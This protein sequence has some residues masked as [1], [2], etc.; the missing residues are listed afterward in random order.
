MLE[1]LSNHRLETLKHIRE[2][3]VNDSLKEIFE[4]LGKKNKKFVD[5]ERWFGYTTLN[6]VYRT[7][8]GKRFGGATT[9]DENEGNDNCR[10]ALRDFFHLSGT[11]V[12][13]DA[14]PYLRWLDVGGYGKAMKKAAK[15]L[16][17]MVGGWPEEHKQRKLCGGMK[18]NQD[19][20]DELLSIV[21]DEDEISSYDADTIVKATCLVR[22]FFFDPFVFL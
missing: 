10:K 18:E 9:K 12:V 7:V 22:A 6:M 4:Q 13:S 1:V 5:M 8:V 19:F 21:T 2:A 14:L 11:F 15:E 20:M 17:H 3:E 16:D